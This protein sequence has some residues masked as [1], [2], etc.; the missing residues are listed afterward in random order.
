[1]VEEYYWVI[2]QAAGWSCYSQS[3]SSLVE[4]GFSCA[5][6][7]IHMYST[8]CILNSDLYKISLMPDLPEFN[9]HIN[10]GVSGFQ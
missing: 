6:L 5:V 3:G 8:I 1:V 9:C 2:T 10:W 4:F 7:Y